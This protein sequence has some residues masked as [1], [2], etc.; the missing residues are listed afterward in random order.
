METKSVLKALNNDLRRE[1]LQVLLKKGDCSVKEVYS[2][3]KKNK[4]K[5]RQ[6]VNKALDL[7]SEVDLVEKY[8]DENKKKIIFSPNYD[9]IKIH[10]DEMNIKGYSQDES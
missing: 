5:Y 9:T 7:L 6:S 3:L 1:T 4:P 8:Y 10:L 2:N